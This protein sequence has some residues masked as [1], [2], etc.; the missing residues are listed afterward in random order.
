[1]ATAHEIDADWAEPEN[2][3]LACRLQQMS[4]STSSDEV[5]D[6]CWERISARLEQLPD[7]APPAQAQAR[8][9]GRR[10]DFSRRQAPCRDTVAQGWSKRPHLRALSVRPALS[11]S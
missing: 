4:W 8:G 7:A 5:R 2:D 6:R 1:M 9:V 3:A 11:L 10:Y